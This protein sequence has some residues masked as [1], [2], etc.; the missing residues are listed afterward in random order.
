ME[1]TETTETIAPVPDPNSGMVLNA[2][3]KYF[4]HTAGRWATF[5]GIMGF[6]GTGIILLCAI[7][8]G[9]LLS[10][11]SRFN[12][13]AMAMPSNPGMPE[14]SSFIGAASG[15]ISFFYVLI[16]LF[17]F[18]VSYYLYRFGTGIKKSTM[19]NDADGTTKSFEYLKSHFKL[20][21]ITTIVII[22][23]YVLMFI[24]G[25]IVIASA[26]SAMH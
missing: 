4:L 11:I 26:A 8:V 5:L 3:A 20:I 12:P 14:A 16:A 17:Y 9:A 22:A 13:A 7:F 2:Q 21:G 15:F 25:I 1:T 18:F 19:F 24:I 23:L 10:L 6:I